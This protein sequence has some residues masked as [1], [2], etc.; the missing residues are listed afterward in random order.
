MT[1]FI[2]LL[3]ACAVL[4]TSCY[5]DYG[6]TTEDYRTVVTI[7]DTTAGA[8]DGL[9]TFYLVDSVFHILGDSTKLDDIPRAYDQALLDGI[10]AN[11]VS[12]GWVQVTDTNGALP[13]TTVR[14]SALQNVTIGYYYNYWYYPWYGYGWGYWGWYY[15]PYYPSGSYYSYTTG[16]VIVEMDRVT[17]RENNDTLQMRALWIGSSNGLLSSSEASNVQY[18]SAGVRQMFDQSPYLYRSSQP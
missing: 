18:I 4:L 8:F 6:L 3:S 11:F 16:S 17:Q 7:Y 15:P 12:M 2:V 13:H 10:A 5:T 9:Q 1:K 14:V